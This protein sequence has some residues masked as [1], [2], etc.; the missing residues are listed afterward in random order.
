MKTVVVVC[1][2]V[3]EAVVV[4]GTGGVGVVGH[5]AE[6]NFNEQQL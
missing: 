1:V 3:R 5:G 4:G 6:L 2:C